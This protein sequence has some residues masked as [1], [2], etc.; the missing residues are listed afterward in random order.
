MTKETLCTYEQ[1]SRLKRLG[2]D[3]PCWCMFAS[4]ESG[5]FPFHCPTPVNFNANAFEVSAPSM[6]VAHRWLRET[7]QIL[8]VINPKNKI[9]GKVYY[10]YSIFYL[11]DVTPIGWS[12]EHYDSYEEAM[13]HALDYA[14]ECA[15][16]QYRKQS[17][18]TK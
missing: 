18:K 11:E 17:T 4:S 6:N 8:I 1:S 7:K 2:F 3:W 16:I 15:V 13:T 12:Y 14:I 10:T 9:E 5:K